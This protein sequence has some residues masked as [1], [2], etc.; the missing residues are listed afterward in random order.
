M[1][2]NDR[3]C[4]VGS[5]RVK[6]VADS[7][8]ANQKKKEVGQKWRVVSKMIEIQI[9]SIQRP[10]SCNYSKTPN[11]DQLTNGYDTWNPRERQ[12]TGNSENIGSRM[13]VQRGYRTNCGVNN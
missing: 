2:D 8:S 1:R 3:R 5:T 11:T 7:K 6:Q 13:T 9:G 4:S 12:V 10:K